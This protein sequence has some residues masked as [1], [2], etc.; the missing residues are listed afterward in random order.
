MDQLIS[1]CE[2]TERY[3]TL[4]YDKSGSYRN[5]SLRV[6]HDYIFAIQVHFEFLTVNSDKLIN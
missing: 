3:P 4:F 2:T 1:F 5:P 6:A